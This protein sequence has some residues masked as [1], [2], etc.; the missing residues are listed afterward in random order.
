[1]QFIYDGI[2]YKVARITGPAHNLLSLR[3]AFGDDQITPVVERLKP[4][5]NGFLNSERVL[6]EVQ[7]GVNEANQRFGTSYRIASL[8]FA[9]DDTPPESIYR[10]LAFSLIERLAKG[11]TFIAVPAE[12]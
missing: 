9:D 12:P 2:F 11:L 4:V 1:M 6:Y 5:L 7:A 10:L 8:Q 3:F